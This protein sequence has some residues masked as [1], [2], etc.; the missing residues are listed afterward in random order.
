VWRLLLAVLA[1]SASRLSAQSECP[2]GTLPAYAHNDYLN[3]RP[4]LDALALG[5][6][7]AEADVFLVKGGLQLG[8]KRRAAEE[9]GIFEEDY[10]TPLRSL[11]ARCGRLTADGH[12]FLLT[13]EI[14]EASRATYDTL[15]A[16]LARYSDLL[17]ATNGGEPPVQVVLVGWYPSGFED[18]TTFPLWR[19][20]YLTHDDR[21]P[22]DAANRSVGLISL[23]YSKTMGRWW[24]TRGRRRRWL[25][26][27]RATKTAFPALRIRVYHLPV[28]AR[29]Y[30]QLL[31]AGVDLIGSQD[32]AESARILTTEVGAHGK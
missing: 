21:P 29:L 30:R 5:Y 2:R 32:L 23:D 27:I 9:D 18:S 16:L 17:K 1:L 25:S 24:V 22:N 19:Q 12:P 10:L 3:E 4:L 13:V 14:K 28:N 7:G 15:V 26:T 8:H 31:D 6:K 11:V 20:A